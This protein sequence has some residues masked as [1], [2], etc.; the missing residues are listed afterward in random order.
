LCLQQSECCCSALIE[1]FMK[2]GKLCKKFIRMEGQHMP[3][4]LRGDQP[5]SGVW[6]LRDQDA[7]KETV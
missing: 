1:I 2:E 7:G 5:F 4:G 3:P 6:E